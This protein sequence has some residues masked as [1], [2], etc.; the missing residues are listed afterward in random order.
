MPTCCAVGCSNNEKSGLKF[1]RLPVG[2]RNANRLKH[3]L[4]NIGRDKWIPNENSRLCVC[5]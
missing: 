2:K 4:H 5:V 1:V 3:W